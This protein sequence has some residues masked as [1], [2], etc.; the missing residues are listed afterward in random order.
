[1]AN[2][3]EVIQPD[4][5]NAMKISDD[6]KER[7]NKYCPLNKLTHLMLYNCLKVILHYF[8]DTVDI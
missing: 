4:S 6:L 5:E 3:S 8:K 7:V 2:N 1:M